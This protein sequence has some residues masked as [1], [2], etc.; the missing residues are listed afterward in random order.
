M[1]VETPLRAIKIYCLGCQG[2]Q[3]TEVKECPTVDCPLWVYRRG[4]RPTKEMLEA[5]ENTED[6]FEAEKARAGIGI[7]RGGN[8]DNAKHLFEYRAERLK[9]EPQAAGAELPW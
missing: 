8:A 6:R 4:R 5:V 1:K 2:W 9:A 3:R 7:S